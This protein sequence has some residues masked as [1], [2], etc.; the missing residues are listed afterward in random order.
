MHPEKA[1]GIDVFNPTFYQSFWDVVKGDVIQFCRRFMYTGLSAMLRRNESVGLVHGCT[2]AR[3][4]PKISLL[5]FADNCYFF[6]R[7]VEAE[8]VNWGNKVISKAGKITLLKAAVQTI[9]NFWMSLFLIPREI[10]DRIERK[11]NAF[12]WCN[13]GDTGGI[14][15]LAWDRLCEVKE[16][17]RLGFKKL[18]EFNVAMLAKQAWRLLKNVNPLVTQLMKARYYPKTDFLDAS[19]GN[20]PNHAWRS[21]VEGKVVVNQG[22]RRHIGDGKD[23]KVWQVA[24]LP[25]TDNGYMTSIMYPELAEVT[26]DSLMKVEDHTWDAEILD[27]MCNDR[28]KKLIY[29]IPIPIKNQTL[30]FGYQVTGVNL[31]YAAT[32]DCCGVNHLV[33]KGKCGQDCGN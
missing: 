14:K 33:K 13:I 7:A 29:Q 9:P 28:D 16:E 32:T 5:L 17:G 21:I 20:N 19:L 15:W 4:A 6:F 23:T 18:C 22:C 2:I 11:M 25:N 12:W 31:Q 26:V 24:W 8:V 10:V 27:E 1:P 3:E 30:G